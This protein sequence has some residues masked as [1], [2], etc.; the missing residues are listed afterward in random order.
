MHGWHQVF[1]GLPESSRDLAKVLEAN[2]IRCFVDDREGPIVTPRGGRSLVSV[3]LVPPEDGEHATEL[4]RRWESQNQADTRYLTGRLK[5]VALLSLLPPIVWL[6]FNVL[7][8][9]ALPEPDIGRLAGVWLASF[10]V[11]A[12]VENRRHRRERTSMPAA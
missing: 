8:P 11:L 9:G 12:Q 1:T 3:V 6:L 10:V 2:G 5:G 7:V 4:T